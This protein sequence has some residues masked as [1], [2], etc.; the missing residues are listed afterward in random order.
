MPVKFIF[1]RAVVALGGEGGNG[2]GGN[3]GG[4]GGGSS[5]SN[6]HNASHVAVQ[7]IRAVV[8]QLASTLPAL[9]AKL[10]RMRRT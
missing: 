3:G 2:G 10:E 1:N 4:G 5:N 6:S 7:D 9:E 8:D